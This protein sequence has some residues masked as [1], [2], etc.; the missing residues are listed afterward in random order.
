MGGK[1][2][3][4]VLQMCKSTLVIDRIKGKPKLLDNASV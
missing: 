4:G 3:L 2:E 1:N